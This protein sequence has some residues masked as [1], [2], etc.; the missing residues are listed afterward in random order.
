MGNVN[1]L[2]NKSDLIR[3]AN[4]SGIADETSTYRKITRRLLPFLMFAYVLC[5]IDRSNI[6]F[7]YLRFKADV[8]LSDA[9]YGFGAGIF[10]LGYILFEVP[11]NM[12]LEKLGARITILRIML[13][14]G[15]ISAA[16]AFVT[17]PFQ[18]YV[19][20]V[21]LGVA[22]AGFFPGLILYLTY[23]FPASRR[24]GATSQ[25]SIA[26][27]I[28]GVIGG[29]ISGGI[30]HLFSDSTVFKSWQWLFLLEGVPSLLMG[31]FAYYYLDDNPRS[32]K[33]LSNAEK[34]IVLTNLERDRQANVTMTAGGREVW[35]RLLKDPRL[36]LASIAYFFNPWSASVLGV[37]GPSIVKQS[38]IQGPFVIG[39]LI[40]V[41]NV[42]GAISMV[43][44]GYHSDRR[45]ERRMHFAACMGLAAVSAVVL[46]GVHTSWFAA[47]LLLSLFS[48]G[49][50]GAFA[51]FWAIPPTYLGRALAPV[52]IAIIS[53]L[54]QSSGLLASWTLGIAKTLTGD[55]SV[56]LHI[57][58]LIEVV[59]GLCI[60]F[61]FSAIQANG[62]APVDQSRQV[63]SQAVVD[64]S[65]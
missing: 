29:P 53:S 48:I 34:S 46:A 19:V 27:C 59:S 56:G 30:L 43:C 5:Y 16:T 11:S 51:V 31:I 65:D 2:E 64:R 18:F 49:Y 54:G 52:G 14:W 1:G 9:A 47:V 58:A 40:A 28:A 39:L 62:V 10:Y 3:H 21:A 15:L 57:V 17:S 35:L 32:A 36:Y 26:L 24:A 55:M 63:G 23:W 13:L 25:L 22:E 45:R 50:Y 60:Y 20:R 41:P 6:S 38:G 61:G 12:L 44:V 37:W 33:W 7:A 42:L 4:E 8:G